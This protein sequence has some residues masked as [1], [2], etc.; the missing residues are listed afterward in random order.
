MFSQP[1]G[2]GVV[3]AERHTGPALSPPNCE[4]IG[5]LWQAEGGY[6]P[7]RPR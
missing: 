1:A 2:A 7:E 3:N 4:I 5:G 6:S